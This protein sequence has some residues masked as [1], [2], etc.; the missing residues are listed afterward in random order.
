MH[1]STLALATSLLV[2]AFSSIS[3]QELKAI[4]YVSA[5]NSEVTGTISFSQ[6]FKHGPTWVYANITGL[7]TGDHGLH[8]HQFG[9]LSNGNNNDNNNNKVK[10]L[11]LRFDRLYL[12]WPSLQSS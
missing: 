8:I 12:Y 3:A 9:D 6:E 11:N 4:A 5:A 2:S 7:T 10:I 1:F